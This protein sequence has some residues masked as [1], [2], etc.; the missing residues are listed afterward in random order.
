MC[1]CCQCNCLQDL[2]IYCT[3]GLHIFLLIYCSDVIVVLWLPVIFCVDWYVLS[4]RH[5]MWAREHCTI[6][7]SCFLTKCHR[8]RL[9]QRS[10]AQLFAFPSCIQHVY[11]LVL[12][13]FVSI[14]QVIGCEDCLQNG[15]DGVWWVVKLHSNWSWGLLV[16]KPLGWRVSRNIFLFIR[17][18]DMLSCSRGA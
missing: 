17:K 7:S 12:F 4:W 5:S 9:N 13:C 10:F 14:N 2:L 18:E 8:R 16:W 6:S 1:W 3:A 15:L 11:F